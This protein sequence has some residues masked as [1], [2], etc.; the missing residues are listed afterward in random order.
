MTTLLIVSLIVAVVY[1]VLVYVVWAVL[2]AF[3][4]DDR[5]HARS[6]ARTYKLSRQAN[7][8][9]AKRHDAK[10]RDLVRLWPVAPVA[11]LYAL[12]RWLAEED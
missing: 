4:L 2:I 6:M 10:A 11:V 1:S 8:A 9:L 12:R 3:A 5:S 7:E